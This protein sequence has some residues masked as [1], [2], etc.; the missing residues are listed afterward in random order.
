MCGNVSVTSP[1]CNGR[2]EPPSPVAPWHAEQLALNTSAPMPIGPAASTG[3]VVS[4][5]TY[6]NAQIG[7]SPRA[8]IAQNGT[9]LRVLAATT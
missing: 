4:E 5:R 9:L 8:A 3:G 2:P 1:S 7:S 6:M